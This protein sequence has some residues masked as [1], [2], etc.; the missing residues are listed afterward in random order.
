M[1]FAKLKAHLRRAA[2][3]TLPDLQNAV[4]SAL[5]SFQ[6]HHCQGF[7]RQAQYASI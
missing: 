6:P 1:A 3:R 2:A 7:F 4:L 5:A